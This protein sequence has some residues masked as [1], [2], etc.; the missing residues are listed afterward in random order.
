MMKKYTQSESFRM[1]KNTSSLKKD[2]ECVN[3]NNL[4]IT[5]EK[6]D[7]IMQFIKVYHP[8]SSMQIGY[9]EVILN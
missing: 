6:I 4:V 2:G 8:V 1:N 7:F 3:L 5:K 9:I